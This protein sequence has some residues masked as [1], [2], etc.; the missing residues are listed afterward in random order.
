MSLGTLCESPSR[1]HAQVTVATTAGPL[2]RSQWA[3]VKVL[4]QQPLG[5][6]KI[7]VGA[8]SEDYLEFC[9]LEQV[10]GRLGLYKYWFPMVSSIL[11]PP[12]C[13]TSISISMSIC[14]A[15]GG[16]KSRSLPM[17]LVAWYHYKHLQHQQ[18]H[19]RHRPCQPL[20]RGDPWL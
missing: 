1:G 11:T 3:E 19:H 15:L 2:V 18:D 8:P 6:Y 13:P 4:Q 17:G 20:A 14:A 5:A 9:F 7:G 12:S 16:R 10:L